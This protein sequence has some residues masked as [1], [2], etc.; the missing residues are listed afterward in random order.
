MGAQNLQT[1]LACAQIDDSDPGTKQTKNLR[2]HPASSNG[3]RSTIVRPVA[4]DQQSFAPSITFD[5]PFVGSSSET[6]SSAQT[7]PLKGTLVYVYLYVS[8]FIKKKS[9]YP[10]K[11][12]GLTIQYGHFSGH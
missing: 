11:R 2:D 1:F 3:F 7:L 10:L 5:D 12:R 8:V 6:I 4:Y 9:K